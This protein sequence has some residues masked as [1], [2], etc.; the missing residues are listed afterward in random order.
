MQPVP[1]VAGAAPGHG[2]VEAVAQVAVVVD[3]E[4]ALV[5]REEVA[6]ALLDLAERQAGARG[7]VARGDVAAQVTHGGDEA[8]LERV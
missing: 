8:L 6:Q 4:V 1:R 7:D 3:V 2:G 5:E